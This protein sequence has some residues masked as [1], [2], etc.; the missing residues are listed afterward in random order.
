[1]DLIPNGTLN[2]LSDQIGIINPCFS[3]MIF[4]NLLFL[5]FSTIVSCTFSTLY[6]RESLSE[7]RVI[8]TLVIRLR[9]IVYCYE[10]VMYSL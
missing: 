1:M 10:T 6:T 4:Q 8:V 5:D 2:A 7:K 9:F 3:K